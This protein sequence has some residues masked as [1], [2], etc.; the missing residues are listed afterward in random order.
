VRAHL[1][2]YL[3]PVSTA[4]YHRVNGC[5]LP[6]A[7]GRAHLR[8]CLRKSLNGFSCCPPSEMVSP[9]SPV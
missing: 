4:H 1:R 3:D 8:A 2:A 6:N 5:K 7:S 9:V